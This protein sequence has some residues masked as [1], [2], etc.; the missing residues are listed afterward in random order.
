[1]LNTAYK[2]IAK[3]IALRL[4]KLLPRLVNQRQT[5][6][7]PDYQILKNISITTMAFDWLKL[8]KQ[9][10]LF[11]QLDFEKAFD[12][13]VFEYIWATLTA[14]GLGVRFLHLIRSLSLGASVKIHV[15]ESFSSDIPIQR[16]AHQGCP[17]A[18]LLFSLTT[19]P[20]LD[21]LDN[22]RTHNKMTGIRI[23]DN[24]SICERLFVDDIGI[25]IPATESCFSEVKDY[26]RHSGLSK[27]E[28]L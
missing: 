3:L 22:K 10:A 28:G 23:T 16:G 1:M 15:N 20:L 5:G 24:L 9:P 8:H 6:F 13:A 21:F 18:P 11:L 2:I 27:L 19:Q 12:R 7:V 14:M 25:L 4:N 17:L 26:V